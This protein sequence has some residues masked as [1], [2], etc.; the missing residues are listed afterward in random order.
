MNSAPSYKYSNAGAHKEPSRGVVAPPSPSTESA[1]EGLHTKDQLIEKIREWVKIDNEI[2]VLQKEQN[3]R[4]AEKKRVSVE[5]MDVMKKNEIDVFDI[6]DGQIVYEKRNVKKPITKTTLFTILS[7]Y[8]DGD[9][10]KAVEMKDYILENREETVQEKIV[11]KL[12]RE[13]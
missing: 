8:Y 9:L 2:R 4:K 5:L 3:R 6:N 11:R 1:T 10:Q 12:K 7:N 13:K